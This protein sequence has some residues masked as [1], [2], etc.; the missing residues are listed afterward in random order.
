MWT[1]LVPV[2]GKSI[3]RSGKGVQKRILK[4]EFPKNNNKSC[5]FFTYPSSFTT[6]PLLYWVHAVK[7]LFFFTRVYVCMYVFVFLLLKISQNIRD[8]PSKQS[9][10]S[11]WANNSNMTL[12]K[13]EREPESVTRSI[14]LAWVLPHSK[15][16]QTRRASGIATKVSIKLWVEA[17]FCSC[18]SQFDLN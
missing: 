13:K 5:L 17:L 8:Q 15:C 12:H 4:K 14:V 3:Q 10:A 16:V 11:S 2:H 6:S 18:L 1:C 7:S 9:Q